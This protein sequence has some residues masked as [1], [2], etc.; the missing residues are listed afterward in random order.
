LFYPPQALEIPVLNQ[1]ENQ[2]ILD[3]D[4]PVNRVVQDFFLI[5]VV[6]FHLFCDTISSVV[7]D[8]GQVSG[9]FIAKGFRPLLC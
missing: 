1:I 9:L 6:Y 2:V 7:F 8:E 5:S 4:K 3:R